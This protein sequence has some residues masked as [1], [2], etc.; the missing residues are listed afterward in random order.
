MVTWSIAF[1]SDALNRRGGGQNIVLKSDVLNML[2][3]WRKGVEGVEEEGGGIFWGV[4]GLEEGG[5]GKVF[6]YFFA[7]RS[8]PHGSGTHA[9]HI[10]GCCSAFADA[11]LIRASAPH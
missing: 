5:W 4:G 8:V 2:G 1:L 10:R 7:R 3:G 9:P 6:F 11:G